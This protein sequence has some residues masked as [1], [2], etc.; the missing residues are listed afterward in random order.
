MQQVFQPHQTSLLYRKLYY[1]GLFVYVFLC[2]I[3]AQ[4]FVERIVFLDTA[5][6]VFHI[7]KDG[8]FAI[9]I[10]RF[11]DGLSRIL[12][13]AAYAFGQPLHTICQLYSVG[14]VLVYFACY[15]IFGTY[16]RQYGLALV[17]LMVN[18]LFVS[19]SFYW[20]TSQAPQAIALTMVLLA[21]LWNKKTA[22]LG[23]MEMLI[24]A[25]LVVTIAFFHPL[26]ALCFLFIAGFFI[27]R[28]DNHID[29]KLMLAVGLVFAFSLLVKTLFFRDQYERQ[30]LSGIKN[31]IRLFPNYFDTYANRNFLTAITTKYYWIAIVFILTL[32]KYLKDK[33][34][35][36]AFFF[37]GMVLGYL[38]LVNTSYPTDKT[39]AFYIEVLYLPLGLFLALPL[40]FDLLP[41]WRTQYAAAM[42]VLIMISG[43]W[44]IYSSH[45]LYTA[46]V[47]WERR[48]LQQYG[49]KKM[50][51][52]SKTAGAAHLQMLWGTPYEFWLLSTME[53]GYSAS[54]II[55][56]SP[57]HRAWAAEKN[58]DLIVNWDV[59]PYKGLNPHY[60][61]LT[62]T[63]TGYQIDPVLP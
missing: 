16:L 5:F 29:R 10:S 15:L 40:L 6:T 2:I 20:P 44:R 14:F 57:A 19:D 45:S 58:K 23:N 30:S 39:P 4:F 1:A 3:A 38:L 21:T 28:N 54:I 62:D 33:Q 52:S 53:N 7:A 41:A 18:I 56:D 59:V 24:S 42:V 26:M 60:F 49:H 22:N 63:T 51:V 13:L 25:A 31:F 36:M 48:F 12:P 32:A 35:K 8:N 11:G 34:Y 47:N 61:R 50:I 17:I 27:L 37:S 55:D 9:Q 43:G 46:R